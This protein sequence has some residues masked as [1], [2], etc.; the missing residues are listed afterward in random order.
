M[1][2]ALAG[3]IPGVLRASATAYPD[4][5]AVVYDGFRLSFAGLF[6][7]SR[8]C[9]RA[10]LAHGLAPGDRVAVWAPNTDRWIIAALGALY[11]G[12]TLVPVNTRLKGAEAAHVL[13][14]CRARALVVDNGFLGTDYVALLRRE[15]PPEE[16]PDLQLV[17]VPEPSG[18][19]T[20]TG[21]QDFLARSAEV[22]AARA[23]AAADA[24]GP[25]A[26]SDIIFTSGTTGRPKGAM[27]RHG[28]SVRLYR[29]WSE[30]VGL[31]AGDRY[32]IVNPFSHTF[33]YKAGLLACLVTG[34]TMLP[35]P[36]FDVTE[37][38]ELIVR[39]RV[40]V[41]PGPPTLYMQLLDHPERAGHDLTSLR[42][43]VTGGAVVPA[44]LVERM[45]SELGF[46]TVLTAYG[47]TESCGTVTMARRGDPD[48]LVAGTSGRA[49]E[50][51][52]VA[53]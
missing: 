50:G 13:A 5:E 14:S 15:A 20:L 38:L 19:P 17:V 31:H 35:V 10:W 32:V 9:A 27:L 24:V 3:T 21:W 18:D 52:E 39:E 51:V 48:A 25:E 42:L 26:I 16:L 45:R 23:E 37:V 33:G 2:T 6:E 12:A 11:A 30:T 1:T 49:V 28:Q 36:V 46:T 7:E 43:A 34:A 8:R 4:A 53:V 29:T 44:A 41:A 22:P 47:L 40:T